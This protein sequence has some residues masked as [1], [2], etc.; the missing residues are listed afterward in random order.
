MIRTLYITIT[1]FLFCV[2]TNAQS[3][4]PTTPP[5]SFLTDHTFG[6][7]ING[8]G[9]LV[10]GTT[11]FDGPANTFLLYDPESD[12]WTTLDTFPGGAR[13]YAIGDVWDGKAYFG[14]G[15]TTSAIEN[16]LWVFDPDSM[17]WT[18]LDTCPCEPRLH[19]AFVAHN[20]KIFAGLGNGNNGNLNDWWEYDIA[21]NQWSRKQDFPN[22]PR[23]HPYQ[24]AVGDY[25]YTGFG[26]GAGIF[27]D[28]YRYDPVN[29]VWDTMSNIPAEGRVAGTQ[30]SYADK[31]YV[32]SGDGED[33]LSMEEGEF[34]EYDP[35]LNEWTQLPPHPG[36]SRWAPASFIIDGVVYL[37]N[38]TTYFNTIGYVYQTEAYKFNLEPKKIY[39]NLEKVISH[40]YNAVIYDIESMSSG[41]WALAVKDAFVPLALWEDSLSIVILDSLGEIE[42]RI[43]INAFV[44]NEIKEM[45]PIWVLPN[46]EILVRYGVGNCDAGIFEYVLEKFDESGTSVWHFILED[47][48]TPTSMSLAPDGN[49][50]YQYSVTLMKISS[51]TGEIMWENAY[52]FDSPSSY[53]FVPGTEDIILGDTSGLKYYSQVIMGDLVTYQLTHSYP[54][55]SGTGYL[56]LLGL[57]DQD[58]FYGMNTES[59]EIYRFRKDLIPKLIMVLPD[60]INEFHNKYSFSKDHL[61]IGLNFPNLE[62]MTFD[63]LGQWINS[64]E[65]E[66]EGVSVNDIE[67]TGEGL[68]VSGNYQ[69]GATADDY[70]N[71][72]YPDGRMEGWFKFISN[73]GD[74]GSMKLISLSVT[75]IEQLEVPVI[76]SFFSPGPDPGTLY[77]ISGGKFRI[78]LANTGE[79]EIHSFSLN[80]IFNYRTNV[81]F[82]APVSAGFIDSENHSIAPGESVW[83]EYV[84]LLAEDQKH[85]PS[86]FCFWTSS[87]NNLPDD[88]PNDDLYCVDNTVSTQPIIENLFSVYPNPADKEIEVILLTE[89][90]D[91]KW[92]LIDTYGRILKKGAFIQSNSSINIS[93]LPEGIYFLI[94]DRVYEKI[95]ICH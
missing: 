41:R 42:K 4:L 21:T 50:L 37:F 60:G 88:Y 52:L 34:W 12:E 17:K 10:A 38:G 87:P 61:A 93:E 40:L 53:L 35:A 13:G 44:Q 14:F 62:V 31:G 43:A 67:L 24:F 64:F 2:T 29:E 6:F 70:P 63:T 89:Y 23:H 65:Y 59:K 15:T 45:G 5:P 78:Q 80:T 91:S 3:W 20:G 74:E 94:G 36:K 9:Y 85:I 32:L 92:S 48:Y 19:P 51:E 66:L 25:V 68:A 79:E 56:T 95:I 28:W 46:E 22:L 49:I 26:H 69:S 47:W 11:E 54:L 71:F 72:L 30:F 16:D 76:D 7:A 86:Q 83:V 82:C 58:V 18:E 1:S 39:P 33:H 81:W 84:G 57:D 77:N 90:T 73:Y 55:E 27:N 75:D 8:K